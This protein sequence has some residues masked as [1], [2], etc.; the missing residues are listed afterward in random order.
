MKKNTAL[1]AWLRY[2]AAFVP[3][4]I[5]IVVIA[6]LTDSIPL[7]IVLAVALAVVTALPLC[8]S[9]FDLID[10]RKYYRHYLLGQRFCIRASSHETEKSA[11]ELAR[12]MTRW[13]AVIGDDA[14]YVVVLRK[15]NDSTILRCT[16][17]EPLRVCD[18]N[19]TKAIRPRMIKYHVMC[20]VV[21]EFVELAQKPTVKEN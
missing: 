15:T 21:S 2:L 8:V 9:L 20:S 6:L 18:W 10:E 12:H 5:V 3:S 4:A 7:I 11:T 13:G 16:R 17:L 1:I 14:D 19:V